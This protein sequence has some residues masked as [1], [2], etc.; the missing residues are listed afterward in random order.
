MVVRPNS[1]F[2]EGTQNELKRTGRH[3]K[4]LEESEQ[5]EKEIV[6]SEPEIVL[7]N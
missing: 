2:M 6:S 4:I 3:L 7:Q 1:G 5:F